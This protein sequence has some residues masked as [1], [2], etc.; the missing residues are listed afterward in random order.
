[1]GYRNQGPWTE[2]AGENLAA[3]RFVMWSGGNVVYADAGD[4]PIGLTLYSAASGASVAVAPLDSALNIVTASGVISAGAAIYVANEGKVSASA[5]GKQI[6]IAKTAAAANNDNIPALVWGPRGGNDL[7]AARGAVCEYSEDFFSYDDT[8][9]VGDYV[10][11]HDGTPATGVTDALNGVLSL[12]TT[13]T[14]NDECYI[15]SVAECWKCVTNKRIFF[16]ARLALTE[17]ATNAANWIIGLSDAVAANSL[18]DNGGGPM[19]SYDGIVFFK[20]DGTM[21]I[22]FE[23]SNLTAQVTNATLAN[24]ASATW[25]KVGFMYDPNDGVTAKVTPFVD[26]VAGTVHDLTIAGMEEMHIL[27]GVKAGTGAAQ[28]LTVDYVHVIAER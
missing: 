2:T 12:T 6:G 13:T 16:E 27:I 19:A 26:G 7:M 8:A 25:Y 4:E 1:M 14:D 3:Y 24:F 28:P 5:V 10:E 21:K 9:T 17:A 23:T 15:S 18:L 11:V 22:Q 20:V